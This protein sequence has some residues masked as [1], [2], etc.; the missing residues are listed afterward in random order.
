MGRCKGDKEARHKVRPKVGR[1]EAVVRQ[2]TRVVANPKAVRFRVRNHKR[3]PLWWAGRREASN[4]A[5]R[6][7]RVQY[8]AVVE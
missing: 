2:A 8:V 6:Y 3:R 7:G 5:L 4:R 1:R